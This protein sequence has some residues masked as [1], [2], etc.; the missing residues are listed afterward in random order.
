V[1]IY[2]NS[3]VD[4][5][6]RPI[7]FSVAHP[8]HRK[9]SA[10]FGGLTWPPKI[11]LFSAASDTAAENS[12]VFGGPLTQPQKTRLFSAAPDT[13]T[14]NK[15]FKN[16]RPLLL[17]CF[18]SLLSQISRRHSSPP[19]PRRLLPNRAAARAATRSPAAPRC[20]TAVLPVTP[21]RHSAVVVKPPH[22]EVFFCVVYFLFSAI[23]IYLPP[24]LVYI[25]KCLFD[26][27]V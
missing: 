13:A 14:E 26:L 24:K 7:L 8:S 22:R 6:R 19:R 3:T 11:R 15:P 2:H 5:F 25:C 1:A 20:S 16:R 9:L 12:L 18:S 23:V 21:S 17:L 4:H 10:I 27:C